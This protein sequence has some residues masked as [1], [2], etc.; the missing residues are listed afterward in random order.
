MYFNRRGWLLPYSMVDGKL[1]KFTG[2]GCY[3]F[4]VGEYLHELIQTKN[5]MKHGETL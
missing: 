3:I 2:N 5:A 4:T 1:E